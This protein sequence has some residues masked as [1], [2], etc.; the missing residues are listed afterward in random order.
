MGHLIIIFMITIFLYNPVQAVE[1]DYS[2]P[3]DL[4]EEDLWAIEQDTE[5]LESIQEVDG[6]NI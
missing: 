2:P 3:W 5:A 4:I 1:F 6:L